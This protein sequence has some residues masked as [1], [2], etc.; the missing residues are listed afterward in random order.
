MG[1]VRR[2]P[3]VYRQGLAAGLEQYLGGYTA[4]VQSIEAQYLDSRHFTIANIKAELGRYEL[5]FPELIG[6]VNFVT[7]NNLRGGAMV[8]EVHR[9]HQTSNIWVREILDLILQ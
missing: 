3:S 6:L 8:D 1:Q 7:S 9:R 4:V 5:I 2:E